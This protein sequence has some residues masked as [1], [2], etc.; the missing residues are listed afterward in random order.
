MPHL[1]LPLHN[2]ILLS[3][4]LHC[5]PLQGSETP[6]IKAQARHAIHAVKRRNQ[7]KQNVQLYEKKIQEKESKLGKNDSLL[8]PL[9]EKLGLLHYQF[10]NYRQATTYYE[11]ALQVRLSPNGKS[12]KKAI[13]NLLSNCG[14][15]YYFQKENVLA[16]AKHRTILTLINSSNLEN[17]NQDQVVKQM[18]M[19]YLF[20]TH[21]NIAAVYVQMKQYHNAIEEYLNAGDLKNEI[22][23]GSLYLAHFY[24]DLANAYY[25]SNQI[26]KAITN[27]EIASKLQEKE[28]G[29]ADFI[30]L[31]TWQ[32]LGDAY[33][34][35]YDF[36]KAKN[37]YEKTWQSAQKYLPEN[38][39]L[40][41]SID[42]NLK[43]IKRE[44]IQSR[45]KEE[46]A[47]SKN[48][49]WKNNEQITESL[50]PSRNITI[51]SKSQYPPS[52]TYM[53]SSSIPVIGAMLGI[54][55]IAK[56]TKNSSKKRAKEK[57]GIAN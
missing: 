16:L 18:Y 38:H 35:N 44:M 6:I 30:T 14:L 2:I 26:T 1:H 56:A 29:E 42:R 45:Q 15:A 46:K 52:K 11:K 12:N 43:E 40:M 50:S 7:Y 24:H 19:N 51:P 17:T 3:I 23:L 32:Q 25:Q 47:R 49:S 10:K 27:Y 5:F 13:I 28:L 37:Y 39:T 34:A 20:K 53:L 33:R 22:S 55:G 4:L 36:T 57:I 21:I 48:D 31:T 9:Y 41:V 8:V 54:A